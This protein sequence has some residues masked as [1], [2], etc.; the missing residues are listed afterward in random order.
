MSCRN[1][2]T[3][4]CLHFNGGETFYT[5]FYYTVPYVMHTTHTIRKRTDDLVYYG[6]F[7]LQKIH[8]RFRSRELSQ[9]HS[10]I[11]F[12]R[13]LTYINADVEPQKKN[14]SPRRN[15]AGNIIC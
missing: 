8:L 10:N 14:T 12:L 4:Y 13:Y 11:L 5:Y 1:F 6:I 9:S 15:K 3:I 2:S 7:Y